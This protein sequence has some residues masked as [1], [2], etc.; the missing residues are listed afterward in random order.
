VLT[1]R[2]VALVPQEVRGPMVLV[3]NAEGADHAG[4]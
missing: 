2:P 3:E 4:P 1:V